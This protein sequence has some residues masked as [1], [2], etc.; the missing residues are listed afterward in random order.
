MRGHAAT[1]GGN[2]LTTLTTPDLYGTWPRSRFSCQCSPDAGR[3]KES[4]TARCMRFSLF[5]TNRIT[6]PRKRK[7][8]RQR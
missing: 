1:R 5:I 4:R 2:V 6:A 8:K 3:D 7:H